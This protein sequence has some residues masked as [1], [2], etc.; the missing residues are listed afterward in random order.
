ML[1]Q[2]P[3]EENIKGR[4]KQPHF[5]TKFM[6]QITVS[7]ALLFHACLHGVTELWL[8][9][10]LC[11]WHEI[12]SSHQLSH[13]RKKFVLNVILKILRKTFYWKMKISLLSSAEFLKQGLVPTRSLRM[14]VSRSK[15]SGWF[16]RGNGADFK[17]NRRRIASW[18][19][20][21]TAQ[22]SEVKK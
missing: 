10:I 20:L 15:S 21:S 4:I 16:F 3:V 6:N 8:K 12:N 2:N 9:E 11:L 14:S 19:K 1:Q 7:S 17:P 5:N 22:R 18:T 13:T